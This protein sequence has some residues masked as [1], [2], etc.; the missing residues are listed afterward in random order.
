MNNVSQ[1]FQVILT[2]SYLHSRITIISLSPSTVSPFKSDK[3]HLNP[4]NPYHP[5]GWVPHVWLPWKSPWTIQPPSPDPAAFK[6]IDEF[7]RKNAA[8]CIRE[9]ARPAA[10]GALGISHGFLSNHL[11][12]LRLPKFSETSKVDPWKV[13]GM[14]FQW[15]SVCFGR[16]D[17][18]FVLESGPLESGWYGFSVCFGRQDWNHL[19]VAER[20]S[21][22]EISQPHVSYGVHVHWICRRTLK[23]PNPKLIR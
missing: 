8:T 6:D 18:Q 16:Q 4:V 20:V 17:F 7:V 10:L 23:L 14:D 15:F 21:Y 19:W 22:D 11:D 2:V 3:P 5:D 13:D 1:L 12:D 9:I